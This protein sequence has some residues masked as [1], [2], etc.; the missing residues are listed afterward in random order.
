MPSDSLHLQYDIS[1]L[2]TDIFRPA[3]SRDPA[4]K[5]SGITIIPNVASNP[6][7]GS[8]IG[9]KAVAG[10]KLGDD[11]RTLMSVAATS[12]SITTRGILNFYFTHNI[13]TN[14]NKWNLQGSM[15]ATKAVTPDFGLG[16]GTGAGAAESEEDKV[17]T[18]PDRKEYVL[19]SLYF[20]FREKAYKEILE[21]FFIGGGVSFDIRTKI[22]DRVTAANEL[23]PYNIY[24]DRF[25]F[26]SE[27]YISNG[28]LF[29]VQ[30]TSRSSKPGV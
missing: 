4:A 26:N 19:H 12:A 6:S 5:R 27:D 30:Y 21:N 24:T 1:D 22:E 15:V 8:Q 11:P 28:L 29:S 23:S 18:N 17:L 9:I 25:G 10:I 7:I 3:G 13:F 2:A 16:I 20:N 14:A